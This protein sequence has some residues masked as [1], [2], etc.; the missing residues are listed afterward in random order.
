MWPIWPFRAENGATLV[1]PGSHNGGQG[2]DG[3]EPVAIEANPGSA[4]IFLGSTLHGAGSNHSNAVRRRIIVSYCLG[5]L[6]PYEKQWLTY[7][8]EVASAFA[9]ELAAL[10]GSQQPRPNLGHYAEHCPTIPPG[11]LPPNHLSTP[12]APRPQQT[13]PL[14]Q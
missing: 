11:D 2:D 14:S 1:G 13:S 5:W 8:P 10:V 6:K 9:P 4:I 3:A 7:P 12:G